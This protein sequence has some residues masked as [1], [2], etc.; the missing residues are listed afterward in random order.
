VLGKPR[1]I[2]PW[3]ESSIV[4]NWEKIDFCFK[5]PSM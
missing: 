2:N 5:P 4:Q 3:F 1:H